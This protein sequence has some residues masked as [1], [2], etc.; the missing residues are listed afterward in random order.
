[1]KKN[2][3]KSDTDNASELA[4]QRHQAPSQAHSKPKKNKVKFPWFA[5]T[6]AFIGDVL[7]DGIE[8]ICNIF[9]IGIC[10]V[11]TETI[12]NVFDWIIGG[13]LLLWCIFKEDSDTSLMLKIIAAT[14]VESIPGADPVPSWMGI[15]FWHYAKKKA[16]SKIPFG[17]ELV[18]KVGKKFLKQT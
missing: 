5:M 11:I 9:S 12:G 8:L 7:I 17:E 13:I 16:A 14:G 15:V 10:L 2:N 1:M 4:Q 6:I 3:Q 18:D